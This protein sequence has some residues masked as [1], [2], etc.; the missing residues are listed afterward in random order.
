MVPFAPLSQ[1]D[2][3]FHSEG[4]DVGSIPTGGIIHC[5]TLNCLMLF[6]FCFSLTNSQRVS[7]VIFTCSPTYFLISLCFSFGIMTIRISPC[8]AIFAAN[9]SSF[10]IIVLY[11]KF[12]LKKGYSQ[13]Y[14]TIFIYLTIVHYSLDFLSVYRQGGE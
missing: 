6:S 4:S 5:Y 3:V 2:R 13:L 7:I 8:V 1:V 11:S 12:P 14:Y 9:C 10:V